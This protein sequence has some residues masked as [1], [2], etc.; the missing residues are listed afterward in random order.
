MDFMVH[1]TNH[2][3]DGDIIWMIDQYSNLLFKVNRVTRECKL[4]SEYRIEKA[5]GRQTDYYGWNLYCYKYGELL[6]FLP[7]SSNS[8]IIADENG[9]INKVISLSEE[10]NTPLYAYPLAEVND[11]LFMVSYGI[12]KIIC[13]DLVN[14]NIAYSSDI[15]D[16]DSTISYGAIIHKSC[17]YIGSMN[18]NKICRYDPVTREREVHIIDGI[19]EGIGTICF[20]DDYTAVIS[21]LSG[22]IYEW[23]TRDMEVVQFADYPSDMDVFLG[24][25]AHSSKCIFPINAPKQN[26]PFFFQSILLKNNVYFIPFNIDYRCNR[27]MSLDCNS[28][29]MSSIKLADHKECKRGNYFIEFYDDESNTI[30]LINDNEDYITRVDLNEG[31]TEHY[32]WHLVNPSD[33][34]R[35]M[36]QRKMNKSIYKETSEI[37]LDEFLHFVN[38]SC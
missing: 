28:K 7:T 5:F 8:M 15:F 13:F 16:D 31:K 1:N 32:L 2:Y 19:N 35:V 37:D 25:N 9:H 3:K 14:Q 6:Y 21:G 30:D 38:E 11:C 34:R 27:M 22:R 4:V 36:L 24:D 17:L 26:N 10:D 18:S 20:I 12:K 33:Y 29:Q 23:N